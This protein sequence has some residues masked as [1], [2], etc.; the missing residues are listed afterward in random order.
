M[1]YAYDASVQTVVCTVHETKQ[2]A[3]I[4]LESL[5]ERGWSTKRIEE[6]PAVPPPLH[7]QLVE[8]TKAL[9]QQLRLPPPIQ[10]VGAGAIQQID[11]LSAQLAKSRRR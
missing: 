7:Q 11:S 6:L 9:R 2:M 8:V 3:P 5:K 1:F 10:V 4:L